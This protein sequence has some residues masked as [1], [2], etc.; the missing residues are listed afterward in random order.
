M[1]AMANTNK[2]HHHHRHRHQ[3]KAVIK[4]FLVACCRL[5]C[6][7]LLFSLL[8]SLLLLLLLAAVALSGGG[9]DGG[10]NVGMRKIIKAF[11]R[12][13]FAFHFGISKKCSDICIRRT[14]IGRK[15][16]LCQ[17][18][19]EIENSKTYTQ[20]HHVHTH[21]HTPQQQLLAYKNWL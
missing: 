19:N 12:R 6:V 1:P 7:F 2:H 14:E 21:T 20:G 10:G 13:L 15:L 8:F 9:N 18:P 4:M 5:L 16:K 17:K 11:A 3:A